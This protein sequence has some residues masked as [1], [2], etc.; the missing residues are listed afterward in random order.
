MLFT[1]Q[2]ARLD[3]SSRSMRKEHGRTMARA[4]I[5]RALIDGLI[6]SGLQ[7]GDYPSEAAL[8]DRV[9][10]CLGRGGPGRSR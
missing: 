4:E 2:V 7:L 9:A 10:R 5:I 3:R 1:R 6:G 8:R